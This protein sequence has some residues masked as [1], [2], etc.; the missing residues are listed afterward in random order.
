MSASLPKK[1]LIVDND[2]G[3][4]N[5]VD[6]IL[7]PYS[8]NILK[9]TDWG[10]ALY[11]FNQNK[12]DL[13]IV[14][15]RL[16]ELP[17]SALIQKWKNHENPEKRNTAFIVATSN[18]STAAENALLTELGDIVKIAKP[19]KLASLLSA[20]AQA[21]NLKTGKANLDSII[22]N[23]INPQLQSGS[24]ESAIQIAKTK[25]EPIGENGRYESALVHERADKIDEAI[26]LLGGLATDF[27]QNMRY[28]NEL[29][30][31]HLQQGNLREAK[32]AYE[33]A[34]ESA[35]MNIKRVKEL[36]HMYLKT[37]EPSRSIEKFRQLIDLTPETPDIKFDAYTAIYDAGFAEHA[38]AFCKETSTPKE[39]VRHFNNKGVMLAKE[40]NYDGAIAEYQKAA[41]LIPGHKELYRILYNMALSH[42][43]KKTKDDIAKAH[44]LL[45]DSLNL[46]PDYDKAREK[47]EIT[48]KYLK[49]E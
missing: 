43:N 27:P 45:E 19:Y 17:G 38:Q 33:K 24:I 35:P 29:G 32:Q 15:L 7:K 18:Q 5:S 44:V 28:M 49:K 48:S 9:A 37:K 3:A 21:L 26:N 8:I 1:I 20:M 14:A 23:A 6:Q 25:L 46:R 13:C 4:L 30:R 10:S 41:N 31:I 12:F 40:G 16:E 47:L 42:I 39:L 36:A 11:Q 22:I 2:Q 34:D